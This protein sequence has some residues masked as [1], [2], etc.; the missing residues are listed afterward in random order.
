MNSFHLKRY[1]CSH[2]DIF[3]ANAFNVVTYTWT[4]FRWANGNISDC[5]YN[6]LMKRLDSRFLQWSRY[7]LILMASY[8]PSSICATVNTFEKIYT[9]SVQECAKLQFIYRRGMRSSIF[10]LN[11]WNSAVRILANNILLITQFTT[12]VS[13]VFCLQFGIGFEALR[14]INKRI[15]ACSIAQG[16]GFPCFFCFVIILLPKTNI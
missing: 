1:F 9:N 15:T 6:R 2:W 10:S 7:F 12:G 5:L 3:C 11:S 16:F 8:M 4:L 14:N 13:W